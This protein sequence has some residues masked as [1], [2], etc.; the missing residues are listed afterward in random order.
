MS[1][2]WEQW[3][4]NLVEI[5]PGREPRPKPKLVALF[6]GIAGYMVSWGF[7]KILLP[8][9][10]CSYF[11]TDCS[12]GTHTKLCRDAGQTHSVLQNVFCG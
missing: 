5:S 6:R 4:G 3:G 9:L 12:I 7:Q 1:Q 2:A 8:V 10:T 11:Y